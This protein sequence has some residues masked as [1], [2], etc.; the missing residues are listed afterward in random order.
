MPC[1]G[2]AVMSKLRIIAQVRIWKDRRSSMPPHS[3]KFSVAFLGVGLMGHPMASRLL[4]AGYRLTAWNRTPKKAQDLETLGARLATSPA[5]AVRH[6]ECVILMLTDAAAVG[7][8]LWRTGVAES[9]ARGTIVLDMSSIAPDQ[10]RKN[11]L[12]LAER[13]VDYMDA[14]VSGGTKGAAAGSLAIMA[15]GNPSVFAKLQPL[16]EVLGRATLIGPSGSGQVAKL[17]NQ[18]IVGITIGAVAEALLLAAAAGADPAKVR[19]ALSGGFAD[20]TV[21]RQHGQRMIEGN[22]VPGGMLKTHLKDMRA[23]HALATEYELNLPLSFQAEA[24]IES[25]VEAGLGEHDHSAIFLEIKRRH[26]QVQLPDSAER[27]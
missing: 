24:L 6:C 12:R 14:P 21:L 8:T 25:G 5:E 2:V 23:L 18:G 19:E 10:A 3:P 15:G 20:S 1:I 16:F 11:A 4:S 13:G 7:E 27:K 17:A 26:P 22:W 9:V